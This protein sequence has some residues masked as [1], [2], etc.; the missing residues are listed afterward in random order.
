M[1]ISVR[2]SLLGEAH[3]RTHYVEEPAGENP[4]VLGT[5]S[6]EDKMLPRP[7]PAVIE[8]TVEFVREAEPPAPAAETPF[9][10]PPP[11][12]ALKTGDKVTIIK[13]RTSGI[14]Y[15]P[16][17]L[18]QYLGRT[19]RILWTTPGGAMV[20]LDKGATWFPYTELEPAM[21]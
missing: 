1:S 16:E 14:R 21:G 2:L 13:D 3:G 10:I 15:P 8:V 19:G 5:L 6:L 7:A 20:K 11:P 18:E 4:L 12:E 9:F 17:W